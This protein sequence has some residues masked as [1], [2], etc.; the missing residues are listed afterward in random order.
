MRT[1]LQFLPFIQS[2]AETAGVGAAVS[3]NKS[4]WNVSLCNTQQEVINI[5]ELF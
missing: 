2:Q 3:G 4:S 1:G 5:T